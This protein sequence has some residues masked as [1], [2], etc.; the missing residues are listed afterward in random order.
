MTQ[1][2]RREVNRTIVAH[3]REILKE[4]GAVAIILF[5]DALADRDLWKKSRNKKKFI[6]VTQDEETLSEMEK[7]KGEFLG[8]I[9]LPGVKLT[10]M[11]QIKLS[12]V[13]C[14][15]SGIVKT[16]DKI[17]SVTG[18]PG[19]GVLDTMV[20]LDLSRESEIISTTGITKELLKHVKPEV[21][22]VV[23]NLAVE[24]AS[25]GR[26]GKPAG[27]T[28]VVGDN[29]KVEKLSRPLIMN[30]FKG[31]PEEVR[32]I[33]DPE[34]HETVKEFSILDGAIII[35][36][37]G[38]VTAA[39]VHLDAALKEEGL[40][41][42]LGS[43][44]MAAAGITDVTD[45]VAITISGSTGTVRVFKNGRAILKIER[46]PDTRQDHTPGGAL[47]RR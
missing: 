26:E 4:T 20:L 14:I 34:V 47:P 13:T 5:V 24:L 7:F 45:A 36:E 30:P 37:D 21:L 25:E 38:V 8:T 11:S 46:S 17:I 18:R 12:A 41:P 29:E 22:K 32:N 40:L 6:L 16:S 44:H 19:S 3:A 35:R 28:F 27:T 33:L 10:R 42:G 9:K 31:Y 23:L 39:G 2:K 1:E 15:T 43:R